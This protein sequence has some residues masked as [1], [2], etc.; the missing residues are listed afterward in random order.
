MT[1]EY[2]DTGAASLA[3][4]AELLRAGETVAFPTE[5]VY[6]LGA[7]ARSAAAV[8]RI[9]EAKGRPQDNPLI[10]HIAAWEELGPLVLEIPPTAQAL[11][12]AYWP[13]PLTMIFR[14]SEVIPASVSGGLDTLAVRLPSHPVARELIRRCGF[15]VAAPSA[16]RS[17]SPSPT[18]AAHVAADLDGRIAAVIDGGPCS[19]GVESTVV[20]LTGGVPRL[21]RPGGVTA[22]MIRAVAGAC[23]VDDAVTHR[24]RDG[25]RAASPGMKYKHYA[26]KAQV[27]LVKGTPA[28]YRAYVE[29]HKAPGTAALCFD[30]DIPYLTVPA[31]SYGH[32]DAPL[33]QA[34]QVFDALRR[35]DEMGAETVLAACPQPKGVGLAVY[36]R[37][38]RAAAFDIV[39]TIRVIGLTGPPG[40]GKSTAAEVWRQMGL[41]VIDCDALARQVTQPDSPCLEAL[42]EAFGDDIRRPDGTLDR[43]L[44]AQRAFAAPDATARLN[45]ITHPAILALI[46]QRLEDAAD[47]G[48]GTAVLDAPTLFEAGADALCDTVVAVLAPTGQRLA[49][50][51]ARDNLTP[52]QAQRRMAAQQ[53][54]GFYARPGVQVLHNAGSEKELQDSAARLARGWL[55]P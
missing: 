53:P 40:A 31:L 32:R 47:A 50:I 11:A 30:E 17:G 22:E 28:A 36:N 13:G 52:E 45:A 42:T 5:T 12:E 43:A 39:N 2:L 46:R 3:R 33:E 21:L 16:N 35:L 49:R 6:G 15:P 34:Q 29:A 38:I 14:R 25:A 54:D 18:T 19:V 55:T 41:P 37:M 4:A 10:V 7:D 26:P 8:A 48:Y 23:E 51:Q 9:F 20:D 24:L 1:T 27:R 44:L